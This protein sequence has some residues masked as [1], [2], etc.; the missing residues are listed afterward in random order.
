MRVKLLFFLF[1]TISTRN[2]LGPRTGSHKHREHNNSRNRL[3]SSSSHKRTRHFR[4]DLEVSR[5]RKKVHKRKKLYSSSSDGEDGNVG[6]RSMDFVG[7]P[8]GEP[9][10]RHGPPGNPIVW[11]WGSDDPNPREDNND[12][13]CAVVENGLCSSNF[14]CRGDRLCDFETGDCYGVSNC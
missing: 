11:H 8:P 10:F 7:P 5:R 4:E 12:Y 2:R 1:L 9:V 13:E 14:H 3:R 6:M